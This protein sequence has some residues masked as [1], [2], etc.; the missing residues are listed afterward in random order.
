MAFKAS[1]RRCLWHRRILYSWSSSV[2]RQ[3]CAGLVSLVRQR[4]IGRQELS[5]HAALLAWRFASLHAVQLA[6]NAPLLASGTRRP[7]TRSAGSMATGVV[8]GEWS[9]ATL[10]RRCARTGTVQAGPPLWA[11]AKPAAEVP[12][13]RPRGPVHH[14]RTLRAE[15]AGRHRGHD[16]GVSSRLS[17]VAA[18]P[19]PTLCGVSDLH[20][21]QIIF[22]RGACFARSGVVGSERIALLIR[23]LSSGTLVAHARAMAAMRAL[24]AWRSRVASLRDRCRAWC[25]AVP[26]LQL[27]G[28]RSCA[29]RVCRVAFVVWARGAACALVRM[30]GGIV[31]V[32][33][34]FEGGTTSM[35]RLKREKT[36]KTDQ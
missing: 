17:S 22:S 23:L 3:R 15:F 11:I 34:R 6:R 12:A 10:R 31:A 26:L 20:A 8:F 13:F 33:A 14:T 36:H 29:W 28:H 16:V 4:R 19:P 35:D 18:P 1:A 25:I 7:R 32:R 21:S 2:H 27:L 30:S 24:M 5:V 9:R